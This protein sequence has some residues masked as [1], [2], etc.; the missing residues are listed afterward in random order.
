VPKA[1]LPVRLPDDVSF[2]LPGNPLDRHAAFRDVACPECGKPARRET[3]TMDTFAR[4]TPPTP[5]TG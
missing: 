1:D 3:D 2:D 4:L 5:I